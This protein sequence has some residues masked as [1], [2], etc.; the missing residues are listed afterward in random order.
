M[1]IMDAIKTR[2]SVRKFKDDDVPDEVLAELFEA[3]R[4]AP[5]WANTQ[6][7]RFIVI[8]NKDVKERLAGTLTPKNPA[9]KAMTAAPVIIVS[10]AEKG[11]SGF[12][13]SDA[14]TS[15]G[16]WLMF[17]VAL[18]VQNLMLAAHS[19][20]LGTV[21]VGAFNVESVDKILGLPDNIAVL[22]MVPI[23]YPATEGGSR[24]PRKELSEMVFRE[25]YGEKFL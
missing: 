9:L 1:D 6:C 5:S 18:S 4:W 7:W 17:D 10:C 20:G 8:R 3:A 22:T 12:Y 24:T 13:R 15:H 11:V 16:D 23:G 21:Q 25:K 19:M 2:R 14:V